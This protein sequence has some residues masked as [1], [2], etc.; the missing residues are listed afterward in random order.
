MRC[1]PR[2][3]RGVTSPRSPAARL[4]GPVLPR[5]GHRRGGGGVSPGGQPP[6]QT[7]TRY[8]R[9][10]QAKAASTSP[11]SPGHVCPSGHAWCPSRCESRRKDRPPA[12]CVSGSAPRPPPHDHRP[13]PTAAAAPHHGR[14]RCVRRRPR[15]EPGKALRCSGHR[16]PPTRRCR[17]R[18]LPAARA[19]GPGC[20]GTPGQ[21]WGWGCLCR[22]GAGGS[23]RG[24][25]GGSPGCPRGGGRSPRPGQG[26][27]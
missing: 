12:G 13:L 6:G 25:P 3:P 26:M 24:S 22:R 7:C 21:P 1:V 23:P 20:R 16:R 4:G 27:K 9:P 2:V 19:V 14:R 10:S 8:V 18:A 15:E 5:P 11:S 17:A